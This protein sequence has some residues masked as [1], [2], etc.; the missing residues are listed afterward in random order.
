MKQFLC[1]AAVGGLVA[2]TL[3]VTTP[4]SNA[5]DVD[6]TKLIVEN[7]SRFSEIE[8]LPE[9]EVSVIIDLNGFSR[10][11]MS[12]DAIVGVDDMLPAQLPT[13]Y[14]TE[15][16]IHCTANPSI[17]EDDNGCL[18]IEDGQYLYRVTD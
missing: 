3:C 2:A 17:T 13:S 12:G 1:G 18:Y 7:S 10:Y 8:P 4:I 14:D 11:I 6:G 5:S 9:K 16:T 15:Q